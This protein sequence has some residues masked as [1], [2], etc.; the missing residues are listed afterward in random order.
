MSMKNPLTPAG[1]EPATLW[2]VAQHL[3][4]CATA[5]PHVFMD[6]CKNLLLVINIIFTTTNIIDY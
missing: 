5:A 2:L 3:N 6:I 1:N 4:R